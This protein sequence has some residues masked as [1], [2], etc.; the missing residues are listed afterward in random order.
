MTT[1][2]GDDEGLWRELAPQTLAT[3]VRLYGADRFE[4]CE[5]AVQ[6]ALLDAHRQWGAR[7]PIDPRAWLVTTARRR[8]VDR[9]RSDQRRR[10]REARVA[11]LEEPLV[12]GV[13]ES[14]DALLLL[15]LCCHPALPKS[16]QVAL[17]LR[18]VAGLTSAQIANAYQLPEA[19][20]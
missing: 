11:L 19:T 7:P 15:Q 5:D 14:D 16:G 12:H 20:I 1:S 9:V 8:Y 18:A 6:D 4:L 13:R 2:F 17:T 10:D 3:L